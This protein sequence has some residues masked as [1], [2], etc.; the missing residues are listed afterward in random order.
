MDC[1]R[2]EELLGIYFDLPEGDERRLLVDQ[3]ILECPACAEEFRLWEESCSLI[4]DGGYFEELIP[5]P[6]ES[7]SRQVMARIYQDE[8]WRLP[9]SERT[10]SLPFRMRRNVFAIISLCLALFSVSLFYSLQ[11][12]PAEPA[13]VASEH[14]ALFGFHQ[15]ASF[16]PDETT[17]ADTLSKSAVASATT[18]FFVEPARLDPIRETPNYWLAFSII[19]LIGTLLTLNWITRTKMT[20]SST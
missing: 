12:R 17:D 9:A 16:S 10:F 19:G 14:S 18:S 7:V 2:A 3:H 8:S 1:S 15:S 6:A 13:A 11:H 20:T 4:Q 5:T